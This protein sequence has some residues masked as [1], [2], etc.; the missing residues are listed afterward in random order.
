M[1]GIKSSIRSR[2]NDGY[3]SKE[4]KLVSLILKNEAISITLIRISLSK[5]IWA[6]IET[7]GLKI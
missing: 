6:L 5:G 1:K 7:R 4:S 2:E 3:G